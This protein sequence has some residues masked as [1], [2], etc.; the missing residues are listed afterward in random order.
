MLHGVK[1]SETQVADTWIKKTAGVVEFFELFFEF[2][3][4]RDQ[5]SWQRDCFHTV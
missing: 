3:N 5:R 2:L 4:E 1:V